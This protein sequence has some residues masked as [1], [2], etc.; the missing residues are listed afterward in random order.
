MNDSRQ[1][2][3]RPAAVALSMLFALVGTSVGAAPVAAAAKN[4]I[5]GVGTYL[6]GKDF[7][8]GVYRSIGNSSCYWQRATDASGSTG[9]IIA[10]DIGHGQRLVY[11]RPTDKVFKTSNCRPWAR[12]TGAAM[13]V[14]SRKAT[15]PGN[16][17]HFV[18]SDFRPGT[19]R[20]VGNK[21]YCYWERSRSAD[22]ASSNIIANEISQG[23]L[24]VTITAGGIFKSSGCTTWTRLS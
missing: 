1:R 23:Q 4:T 2:D 16:G 21:E 20:S 9:S 11:V 6:V 7:E 24:I 8:A 22:G 13:N 10:N 5:P 3:A 18:G 15:I 17:A 14:K 12:V 19:Y